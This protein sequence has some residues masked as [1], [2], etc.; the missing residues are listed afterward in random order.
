MR[1]AASDV[2]PS[3]SALSRYQLGDIVEGDDVTLLSI[4]LLL[5]GIPD[6]QI[7]FLSLTIDRHLSLH[8]ALSTRARG[9]HHLRELRDNLGQRLPE[10]IRF[11]MIDQALR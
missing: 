6:R 2:G 5:A 4:R 11:R 3:R 10:R 7:A 9:C 1:D 8:K